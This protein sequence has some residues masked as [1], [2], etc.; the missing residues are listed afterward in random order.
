MGYEAPEI[1]LHY[2]VDRLDPEVNVIANM[3]VKTSPFKGAVTLA[4]K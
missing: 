4:K 3:R 2:Q 1:D